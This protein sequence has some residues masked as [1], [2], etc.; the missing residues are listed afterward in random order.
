M[1]DKIRVIICWFN[2]SFLLIGLQ[3]FWR[4]CQMVILEPLDCLITK[5]FYP[6]YGLLCT[7]IIILI[8]SFPSSTLVLHSSLNTFLF[9]SFLPLCLFHTNLTSIELCQLI[10]ENNVTNGSIN[11]HV[12][13]H[14]ILLVFYFSNK[15]SQEE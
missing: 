6:N 8:Y 15:S 2:P 12:R 14:F 3:L 9:F 4:R 7:N 5:L 1:G 13:N 10:S 11:L